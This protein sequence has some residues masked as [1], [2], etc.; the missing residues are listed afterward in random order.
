MPNAQAWFYGLTGFG[1]SGA[2]L[3]PR[4]RETLTALDAMERL[5]NAVGYLQTLPEFTAEAQNVLA[6]A[7][8]RVAAAKLREPG[9]CPQCGSTDKNKYIIG[10]LPRHAWHNTCERADCD[11]VECPTHKANP[12]Y[13]WRCPCLVSDS[14]NRYFQHIPNCPNSKRR[15]NISADMV[16]RGYK[17][18]PR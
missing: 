5:N 1:S 7:R 16:R 2:N 13:V 17:G 6:E 18:E 3:K 4:D 12:N 15:I 14:G 8:K 11:N 9:S 10:C